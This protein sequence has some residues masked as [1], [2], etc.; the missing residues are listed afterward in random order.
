MNLGSI[1][2]ESKKVSNN[3]WA[4]TLTAER[5]TSVPESTHR[6]YVRCRSNHESKLRSENT[7]RSIYRYT[8]FVRFFISAARSA[9]RRLSSEM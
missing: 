4:P 8:A 1:V 2:G 3:S 6:A 7:D 5:S 9:P